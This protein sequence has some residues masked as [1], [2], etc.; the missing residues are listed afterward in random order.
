MKDTTMHTGQGM[1]VDWYIY[2]IHKHKHGCMCSNK[3][4]I[5]IAIELV[6][7]IQLC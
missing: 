5:K 7:L 1:C 2:K 4:G 6:L 3:G